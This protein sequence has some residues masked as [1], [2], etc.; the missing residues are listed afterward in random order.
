MIVILVCGCENKKCI[1]SHVEMGTCV[2]YTSFYNGSTMVMIPHFYECEKTV[3]DE[4]ESEIT[5]E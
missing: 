2:Y 4:Y 1:K 5:N 3:C